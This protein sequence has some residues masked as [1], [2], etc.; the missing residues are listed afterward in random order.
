MAPA[1]KKK[2][3]TDEDGLYPPVV[4]DDSK[5]N[6]KETTQTLPAPREL[7]TAV[8]GDTDR[9][10]FQVSPLSNH[11]LMT[12]QTR[13]ALRALQRSSHGATILKLRAFVAGSGDM[14]RIGE[15]VGELWTDRRTPLPAVT[16]IQ[17][18]GLPMEGAQVV[19]ESIAEDRKTVNPNGVAFVPGQA[20]DSID[21]SLSKIEKSLGTASA[22]DVLRATCF[23]RSLDETRDG[24][25]VMTRHF[26][27]AALNIV[28]AQRE[29][30]G[31]VAECEGVVRANSPMTA[32]A[33]K[34]VFSAAQLGFGSEDGDIRLAFDRLEKSLT[35]WN[36]QLNA[37]LSTHIYVMSR[38]MRDK[39]RAA[40]PELFHSSASTFVQ[41]EGLPSLD[42]SFGVEVIAP[43]EG[44]SLRAAG[45]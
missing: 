12:V 33:P 28:Q 37:A 32:S 8:V 15:I 35:P 43:A 38:G 11:G 14:R 4:L 9:L 16:V 41:V 45:R 18:G 2:K 30:S 10:I 31:P 5:K 24:M 7:P 21:E 39:V 19:I 20:A 25:A 36:A 22:A 23:V 1:Q 42:A 17:T 3:N 27:G 29:Y 6:K 34:L 13:D 26:P 44:G 40:R